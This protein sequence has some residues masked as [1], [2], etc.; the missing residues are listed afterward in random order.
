MSD[1][2]APEQG[3]KQKRKG[4]ALYLLL[5]FL[6]L[7]SNGALGWLWWKDKG[8]MHIITIEKESVAKDAEIVKLELTAL[9]TQYQYL[10]VSNESMQ[11]QIDAKK[12]EIE[13]LQAELEKHK[14]NAWIIAKLRKETMTL[15]GIMQHFVE[16]IDSLNTLNKN[17]IAEKEIVKK[18]LKTEKE[19][20]TQLVKEKTAL[21][22]TVTIASIL[23]AVGI[24]AVGIVEKRNGKKE[25]ETKKAKRTNKI[26]ISFTLA[27]NIIAKEGERTIYARIVSPDGREITPSDD[28]S[29]VFKF[30]RSKGFWATKKNINYANT[31]TEVVMYAPATPNEAFP[32]GKYIIH[33]ACDN[34]TIGNTIL[35][36][37]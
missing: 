18:E 32:N 22:E 15:R 13:K 8:K 26:K 28:S 35:E 3:K 27:E 33:L 16:E 10:K 23:K 20:N 6:L 14:D 34:A 17:V 11:A 5:I 1:S 29:H 36:L 25:S 31:N 9:Q 2:N 21:Q 30:E 24:N 37:E 7:F 4:E 19:K 12:L